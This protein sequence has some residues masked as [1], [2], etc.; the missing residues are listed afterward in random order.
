MYQAEKPV[1][2]SGDVA[3]LAWQPT[4]FDSAA[5]APDASFNTVKRHLLD[6]TA[7]V[8]H[9]PGWMRGADTLFATLLETAPWEAS[10]QELYGRVVDTPRLI[11]R[12]PYQRGSVE[13]PPLFEQVRTL[14]EQRYR[15]PFNSVSANLYRDGRD[16]VAWHGDRIPRTVHNPLVATIS[17]GHS[18]RFLMR[19]RGGITQLSLTLGP[20]D[21]VVM[22]GTS[23][24]TWQHAIPKVASAGPRIS[25]AVRHSL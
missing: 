8:D 7:W 2:A 21:L 6:A 19:P 16:S 18:R 11:A 4:L 20:G 22:G 9:A 5:P 14:L 3:S 1:E 17:L 13:R 10:Q 24:R 25:I 12:W 15:R 23:Q